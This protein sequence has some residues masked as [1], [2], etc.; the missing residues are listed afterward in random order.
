MMQQVEQDHVL[1]EIEC[2]VCLDVRGGCCMYVCKTGHQV[3]LQLQASLN[4]N[5]RSHFTTVKAI[6]LYVWHYCRKNLR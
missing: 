3:G 1:Q 6:L 5:K 4:K 2:P